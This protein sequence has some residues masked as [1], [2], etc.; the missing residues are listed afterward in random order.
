M[1]KPVI[2]VPMDYQ[3]PGEYSNFPW[4]ALRENYLENI[5]KMGGVPLGFL[6]EESLI[7]AYVNMIDG[8]LI[9]GAGFDIDPALYGDVLRHPELTTNP[10]RTHFEW[11]MI[12]KALTNNIP[13]LGI[14]G[15]QQLLNV[16]LGGKLIQHIP[17]DFESD[18]SHF[19]PQKPA[20]TPCHKVTIEKDTKLFEIVGI[21]Q[22]YVNSRHHQAVKMV[23]KD[24]IIN[25]RAEDG[26]IEG[27][28]YTNHPFCIGVQ[29]H[30]EFS[31]DL[32]DDSI[33]ES[34]VAA[35]RK[36]KQ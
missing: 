31:I 34:F 27:I 20:N 13:I 14:C 6:N 12:E 3:T 4:Y 10:K 17:S 9:T 18:I 19:C 24:V 1:R 29:W 35:S 33:I 30:P 2:G 15:G 23:G 16:V 36:Y 8:L 7:D 5:E 25:A 21:S 22:M 11:K 28:E 26:L 32:K